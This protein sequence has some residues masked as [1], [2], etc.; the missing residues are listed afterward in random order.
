MASSEEKSP[1]RGRSRSPTRTTS[2]LVRNLVS[3][4]QDYKVR[5]DEVKEFFS[6]FG[7]VRDVYLPVDYYT[8]KPKG[9]GFVEF[10]NYE[11]AKDALERTDNVEVL[12][13]V[14]KVVFAREGRK[15]V[16]SIQPGDMRSRERSYRSRRS[17]PPKRRHS[18]DDSYSPRRS[19]SR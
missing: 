10:I 17:P 11:D 13:S 7:E 15:A 4:R 8:R 18:R 9:F 3:S 12:G 14:V 1:N 5:N 19:R 2:L 6:R 16:N